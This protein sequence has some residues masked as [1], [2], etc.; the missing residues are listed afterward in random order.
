MIESQKIALKILMGLD[1]S[2]LTQKNPATRLNVT[3]QQVNKIVSGKENLTL[4][5][6]AKIHEILDIPVPASYYENKEEKGEMSL[7]HIKKTKAFVSE[8]NSISSQYT[9]LFKKPAGAKIKL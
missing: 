9:R 5:T 2:G 1:E 4:E 7:R 3:P 6:R 8:K